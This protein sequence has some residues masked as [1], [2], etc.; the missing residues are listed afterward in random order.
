MSV[1][2]RVL[3]VVGTTGVG[4]TQLGVA[5]ARRIPGAEIIS[6]DSMQVYRHFNIGS[7]KVTPKEAQGV[8]H[9]CINFKELH[10][11]CN[12]H[13]FARTALPVVHALH[14]QNQ[15]PIVVGG[16]F[17]Y[18]EALL[19]RSWLGSDS[20][21]LLTNQDLTEAQHGEI[22]ALSAMDN[23]HIFELLKRRDA[24]TAAQLHPN[25]R[26][27]VMNALRTFVK[28]GRRSS[29]L[30]DQHGGRYGAEHFDTTVLWL[31]ADTDELQQRI[32][33]RVDRMVTDGVIEEARA[34]TWHLVG[35]GLLYWSDVSDDP[36]ARTPVRADQSRLSLTG[37]HHVID[38][39]ARVPGV[40]QAIG[41]KEFLPLF[42]REFQLLRELDESTS[43]DESEESGGKSK[44]RMQIRK[45]EA[46]MARELLPSLF[47]TTT[48]EEQVASLT[49]TDGALAQCRQQCIDTLKLRTRQYAK[50]QI[51]WIRSRLSHGAP[52]R[53][54]RL[55]ARNVDRQVWTEKVL[56]P[57][58]A[59]ADAVMT[60][61]ETP[62]LPQWVN[63]VLAQAEQDL[64]P[65]PPP[66][67]AQNDTTHT[68]FF[69]EE[70]QREFHGEQ[71]WQTHLQSRKHRRR[72]QRL[73]KH[74]EKETRR[75]ERLGD[76]DQPDAKRHCT[77]AAESDPADAEPAA[78][79]LG[80]PKDTDSQDTSSS[81]A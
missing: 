8:P 10:E 26:R 68:A 38:G 67:A 76:L 4:K 32:D 12:A 56:E 7:A 22:S 31:D 64:P 54:F 25:D 55:D 29:E 5:L 52:V 40:L 46:A 77:G 36:T 59:I 62:Q 50:R 60:D 20:H 24:A 70:C 41:L 78:S 37:A 49:D 43:E 73:K 39:E 17:L 28:H 61:D 69:C 34:I 16:T 58:L 65:R 53:V 33:Q 63:D 44:S 51:K 1:R 30:R 74:R 81:V 9:H 42:K 11:S 75:R 48:L 3:A 27:R 19:F 57:A 2:R 15:V 80:S 66:K 72:L 13:E 47:E 14:E 18:T 23:R 6:A 71:A 79:A 21:G 45:E 35:Q